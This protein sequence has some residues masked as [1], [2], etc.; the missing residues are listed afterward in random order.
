MGKWIKRI[1]VSIIFIICGLL[2]WR[3]CIAADKSRFSTPTSTDAL[4]S[5]FADGES[6]IY[7]VDVAAELADDGYFC[8]YGFYYNPESG[9]VQF[10]VRWNDSVYEY[11][12]MAEGHEYSFYLLNE[13][14]GE[15]Y[16]ATV[17]ES[18]RAT[19]YNY[20]HLAADGVE[21]GNEEN[22]TAVMELRDG[23]ESKQVLKHPEQPFET[24]K[25]PAKLM[26]ELTK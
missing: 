1:G 16:P 18:D 6:V 23:Y 14:T 3:C 5:A 4:R 20:R 7:T 8:A 26:K 21:L 13:T 11:T 12:D 25:I 2:I 15:K 9:E 22:L 24:Y 17:I 10:A 19:L